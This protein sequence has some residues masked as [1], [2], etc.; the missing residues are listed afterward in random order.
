M[1]AASVLVSFSLAVLFTLAVSDAD[2]AKKKKATTLK[3]KIVSVTKVE[4]KENELGQLTIKT[5]VK[6]GGEAKEVKID[7]LKT[8]TVEKVVGKKGDK[9]HEAA[10]F[11]DLKTGQNVV[12]QLRAGQATQADKVEF[13]AKKKKAT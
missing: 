1:R 4:D 12:V 9:K 13:V 8:T 3:G 6:K 5:K 2:A 7:V 11:A 10:A